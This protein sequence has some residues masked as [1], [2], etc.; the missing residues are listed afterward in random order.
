M[1]GKTMIHPDTGYD[2]PPS[3]L[4][5][6]HHSNA[7]EAPEPERCAGKIAVDLCATCGGRAEKVLNAGDSPLPACD[8]R[9]LDP[10]SPLA[11]M[12]S[13]GGSTDRTDRDTDTDTATLPAPGSDELT[14]RMIQNSAAI[15]AVI[16]KEGSAADILPYEERHARCIVYTARE[17]GIPARV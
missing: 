14:Q 2:I 16:E 3:F 5:A 11:A 17:L 7:D 4:R 6:L 10:P 1:C 15:L 8:A 12:M 9:R 13:D